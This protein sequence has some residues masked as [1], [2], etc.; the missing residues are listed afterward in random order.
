MS[1]RQ[2]QNINRRSLLGS[3]IAA[4]TALTLVP[5]VFGKSGGNH[6][7]PSYMKDYADLYKTDPRAAALKCFDEAKFGL[8]LHWGLYAVPA[9]HTLQ[10]KFINPCPKFGTN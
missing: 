7:V 5:S 9:L 4:T 1:T 2:L 3:G 6:S 10:D 8:F